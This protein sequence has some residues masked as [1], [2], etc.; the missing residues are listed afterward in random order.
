MNCHMLGVIAQYGDLVDKT[1]SSNRERL[2][3]LRKKIKIDDKLT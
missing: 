2:E 1:L 3:F